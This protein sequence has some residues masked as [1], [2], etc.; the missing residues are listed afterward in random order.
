MKPSE[1]CLVFVSFCEFICD[2]FS[3]RAIFKNI[4][5]APEK[6]KIYINFSSKEFC[7]VANFSSKEFYCGYT[8]NL[9]Q[10]LKAEKLTEDYN[11]AIKN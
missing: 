3:W 5:P 8:A 11:S 6:H 7:C 2:F 4:A 1:I 9:L 10:Q